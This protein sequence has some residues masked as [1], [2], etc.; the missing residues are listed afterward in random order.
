MPQKGRKFFKRGWEEW[1]RDFLFY[2]KAQGRSDTTV[3]DYKFHIELFYKRFPQA[4]DNYKS[5]K[6]CVYKH[7]EEASDKSSATFNIRREYLHAFFGWLVNEGILDDNPVS[8]I[9]KRKEA[10]RARLIDEEILKKLLSL[11][12]KKTFSGLRDYALILLMLDTGIR[13]K[14]ALSILPSDLNLESYEVLIRPS[15]DKTRRGRT[16]PIT[17]LTAQAI[18]KLLS[19]RPQDWSDDVPVFC[20]YEGSKMRRDG[21]AYRLRLYSKKLGVKIRPYD[22]RHSFA[23]MFLRGGGHAFSLQRMLGHTD[24][25]MTRR[26]VSLTQQDLREQHT[27]ASP[28][29]KLIT[30]KKRLRKI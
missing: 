12:N 27:S 8:K 9:P 7:L 22:L 26:Y 14:E 11:P 21:W 29:Y 24:M 20:N 3:N 19:V 10:S 6:E 17:P 25:T 5:L 15:N 4:H 16:L 18:K 2:K 23:L 13:P 1:L 30:R 28:V